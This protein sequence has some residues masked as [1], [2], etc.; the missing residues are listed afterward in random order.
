MLRNGNT[1]LPEKKE[2]IFPKYFLNMDISIDI[3]PTTLT[4]LLVIL[5]IHMEG[6]MSQIFYIGPSLYFI[7]F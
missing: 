7:I 2:V 4:F 1:S 5:H 6:T 3:L